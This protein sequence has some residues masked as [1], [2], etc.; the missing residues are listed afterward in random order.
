MNTFPS[1]GQDFRRYVLAMTR[2]SLIAD[3]FI[4]TGGRNVMG[5][6]GD[7]EYPVLRRLAKEVG[8]V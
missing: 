5:R 8:K 4:R 6:A 2:G 7:K 1:H 3:N